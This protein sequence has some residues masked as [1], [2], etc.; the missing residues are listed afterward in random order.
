M[1]GYET[2]G[3][4]KLSNV[5]S[6]RELQPVVQHLSRWVDDVARRISSNVPLHA[7]APFAARL[8]LVAIEEGAEDVLAGLLRGM[9][10]VWL[11]T[12]D[13]DAKAMFDLVTDAR[14]M[15]PLSHLLGTERLV[16]DTT[17]H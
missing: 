11:P 13:N 16:L 10:E 9:N 4:A 15:K 8:A 5:F 6:P 1:Q 3:F 7:D 14:L 2:N 12:P 17:G